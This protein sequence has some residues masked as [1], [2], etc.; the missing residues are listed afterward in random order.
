VHRHLTI[1]DEPGVVKGVNAGHQYVVII[2]DSLS[3]H[4][5]PPYGLS[6]DFTFIH[7]VSFVLLMAHYF[8]DESLPSLGRCLPL[9]QQPI[10]CLLIVKKQN[11]IIE[12][13]MMGNI[14][15]SPYPNPTHGNI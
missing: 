13:M 1:E 11:M 5:S 3:F 9:A 15:Q 7:W 10:P 14:H 6:E 8:N 4:A 12:I 2:T